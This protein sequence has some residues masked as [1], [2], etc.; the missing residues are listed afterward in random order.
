MKN[1]YDVV[2][3]ALA[4]SVVFLEEAILTIDARQTPDER[5]D[6]TTRYLNGRGWNYQNAEFGSS[7][8]A[9]I[10][11]S[12]KMPGNRL[13]PKQIEKARP[14]MRKYANQLIRAAAEAQTAAAK[15]AA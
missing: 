3:A 6:G 11:S 14:M 9:W 7:L 8:A 12:W 4:T 2:V 5:D 15:E 1:V 13:T 10:R